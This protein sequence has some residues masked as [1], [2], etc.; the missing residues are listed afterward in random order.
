MT[1]LAFS[2]FE[3]LLT[4]AILSIFAT[5]GYFWIPDSKLHLAQ[6]QI[7]S[8]LNYTR[9]L[10][11]NNAKQITQSAFCQSDNCKQER[12]RWRESLWRMQFSY[13]QDIGYAYYIFSDSARA[14][15]TKNLDDRPRDRQEIAR[16]LLDNK[17]LN[18]YNN[19]NSKFANPLR[20]GD[21]AIT[22]RFG[23]QNVKASGGCGE[24]NAAR[25]LF[26]EKGFLL[27]KNPY[28]KPTTPTGIV[29]LELFNKSGKSVKICILP[30][31][32]IQKC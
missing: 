17:Y 25:I 31:G 10:S 3:T 24:D 23:I 15:R 27:C 26:D 32:F 21:L 20:S 18:V 6:N 9:F 22:Q 12:T 5:L 7:I 30:S 19:D 16:D 1:R 28:K 2:L 8:H 4:L 11:L 14:V 29:S 13:L